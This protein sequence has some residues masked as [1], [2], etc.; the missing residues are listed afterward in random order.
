MLFVPTVLAH[1]TQE[2]MEEGPPTLDESIRAYQIEFSLISTAILLILVGVAILFYKLGLI[3]HEEPVLPDVT[4]QIQPT[5]KSNDIIKAILFILIIV[6][7]MAN[8]FYLIGS[9][10]YINLASVSRGPIHWH[11]EFRVFNC[12]SELD[13]KDPIKPANAVGTHLLHEHNDGQIHIEEAV[14]DWD[15]VTLASF[16]HAVGGNFENGNFTF[17]TNNGDVIM[18]DGTICPNDQVAFLQVFL[19]KA[20]KNGINQTRL[21][22]PEKY[23]ISHEQRVPP[24]DCLIFEFDSA[25]EKTDKLCLSYLPVQE[26][27]KNYGH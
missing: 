27:Q 6:T 21:N 22:Q 23:I 26:K 24:G 12:G 2:S 17:P 3:F 11:A 13:L 14:F 25:K 16:F 10:A 1:G 7:I 8:T 5:S 9:T 19:L 15:D 18:Q 20:D 4:P